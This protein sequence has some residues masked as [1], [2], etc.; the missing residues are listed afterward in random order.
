MS[1]LAVKDTCSCS[2]N[3]VFVGAIQ[4]FNSFHV[5][6]TRSSFIIELHCNVQHF[7]KNHVESTR[8][9]KWSHCCISCG[10]GVYMR[11][12]GQKSQSTD[13][14]RRTLDIAGLG[15]YLLVRVDISVCIV[16]LCRCCILYN[17]ILCNL[18][19]PCRH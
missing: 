13:S 18:E 3:F 17:R 9:T 1:F 14:N 15:K 2:I 6:S 10:F 12:E 19:L 5:Y 7:S 4:T 11:S 8:R 16:L